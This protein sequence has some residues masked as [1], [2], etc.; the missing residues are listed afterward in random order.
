MVVVVVVVAVVVV[1][2]VLRKI[3]TTT[4]TIN[5]TTTTKTTDTNAK[6]TNVWLWLSFLEAHWV[7]WEII[8]WPLDN[9][10]QR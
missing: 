7:S 10:Y 5:T 6:H 9:G 3:R 1:M 4:N 8:N 2:D